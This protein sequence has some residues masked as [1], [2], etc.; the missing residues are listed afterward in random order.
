MEMGNLYQAG[1]INRLVTTARQTDLTFD[2]V[3]GHARSRR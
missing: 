3:S 1:E 2:L